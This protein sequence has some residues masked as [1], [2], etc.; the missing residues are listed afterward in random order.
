MINNEIISVTKKIEELVLEAFHTMYLK[1]DTN[2]C[3]CEN[4]NLELSVCEDEFDSPIV[5]ITTHW[6]QTSGSEY[7]REITLD[8]TKSR[9][10]LLGYIVANMEI[11]EDQ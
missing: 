6:G 7:E 4:I 5:T 10:F 9:E 2:W 3:H 11:T 8:L 1:V